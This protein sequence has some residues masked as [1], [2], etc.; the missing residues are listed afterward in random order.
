MKLCSVFLRNPFY[1]NVDNLTLLSWV[2]MIGLSLFFAQ[3]S[4][5]VGQPFEWVEPSLFLVFTDASLGLLLV[6]LN[7]H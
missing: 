3:P 2:S 7:I 1:L 4:F 5:S 6:H